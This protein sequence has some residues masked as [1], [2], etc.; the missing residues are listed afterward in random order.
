MVEVNAGDDLDGNDRRDRPI[1]DVQIV[2]TGGHASLREKATRQ[3]AGSVSQ[4]QNAQPEVSISVQPEVSVSAVHVRGRKYQIGSFDLKPFSRL[5]WHCCRDRLPS[6]TTLTQAR[7]RRRCLAETRQPGPASDYVSTFRGEGV[8]PDLLALPVGLRF[9][10]D[11]KT[12]RCRS[13]AIDE[14]RHTYGI[15][16]APKGGEKPATDHASTRRV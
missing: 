14:P 10:P 12:E 4:D 7:R 11:A 1:M 6:S 13:Y 15:T 9:N 2:L 16:I 5:S 8:E 3:F